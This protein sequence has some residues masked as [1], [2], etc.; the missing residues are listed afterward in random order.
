M[1]TR[2]RV[3]IED[4]GICLPPYVDAQKLAELRAEQTGNQDWIQKPKKFGVEK[5]SVLYRTDVVEVAAKAIIDLL[6]RTDIK[7]KNVAGIYPS[8]ESGLDMMRPLGIY[9]LKKL[10]REG[11]D[12]GSNIETGESKFSC[13]SSSYA[14]YHCWDHIMLHPDRTL[15]VVAVDR[16]IY[17]RGTFAELTQ[18]GGGIALPVTSNPWLALDFN[19]VGVFTEDIGSDLCRPPGQKTP[20]VNGK[21]SIYAYLRAISEAFKD[22]KRK[23]GK[24][25]ILEE[26]HWLLLHNPY[27]LMIEDGVAY[28]LLH[29]K[30]N[31][32][33]NEASSQMASSVLESL[34]NIYEL[35][36]PQYSRTR[37]ILRNTNLFKEF[38]QD[39]VEPS[40]IATAGCGNLYT[41]AL[42]LQVMSLATYGHPKEGDIAGAIGFGASCGALSYTGEFMSVLNFDLKEKLK[43]R[44]EIPPKEY[45]F[46]RE[47]EEHKS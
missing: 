33:L 24:K 46:W 29:E 6:E 12:F 38:F 22:Y 28:L 42:P 14:L 21:L 18:G 31:E 39:K 7:P 16:A 27:R 47:Y 34:P 13:V 10:K 37:E 40:T 9:I 30:Y 2:I 4:M 23:T 3:G 45:D 8:T 43:N 11:Y 41:A 5:F 17:E 15:I 44:K 19:K 36:Q 35:A 25:E 32:I 20:T 26:L 1:T